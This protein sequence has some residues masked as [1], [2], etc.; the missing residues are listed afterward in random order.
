MQRGLLNKGLLVHE[1]EA[2]FSVDSFKGVS[3][4]GLT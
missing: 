3:Y 4:A 1:D 2:N